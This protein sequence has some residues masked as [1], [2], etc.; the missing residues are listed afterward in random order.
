[1]IKDYYGPRIAMYF[2]FIAFYT[3][4]LVPMSLLGSILF[5]IQIYSGVIDSIFLPI[6]SVALVLW[7]S[8]FLQFWKRE[9]STLA[10]KWKITP[11]E[12]KEQI[13]EMEQ[14]KKNQTDCFV[15]A[16]TKKI[17][18][19]YSI[20]IMVCIALILVYMIVF[21]IITQAEVNFDLFNLISIL[22]SNYYLFI[23]IL[24]CI[25]IS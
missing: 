8:V 18:F 19:I 20:I 21:Y 9:R 7:G 25:E 13:Q 5:L 4:S 10:A 14:S 24:V 3:K 22:L 6:F 17:R 2:A 11:N 16:T 15:N 12:E 23:I 1:M